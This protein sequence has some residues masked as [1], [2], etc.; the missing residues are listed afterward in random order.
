[1][2]SELVMILRPDLIGPN[3]D[4]LLK[5]II[6]DSFEKGATYTLTF[7]AEKCSKLLEIEIPNYAF[8]KLSIAPGNEVIVSLRRENIFLVPLQDNS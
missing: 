7:L 4:N 8:Y 5:G 6:V 1:I 3:Q 2:R